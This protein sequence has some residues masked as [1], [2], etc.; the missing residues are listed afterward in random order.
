VELNPPNRLLQNPGP[1]SQEADYGRETDSVFL[2]LGN[3][4]EASN[5][6]HLA[7]TTTVSLGSNFG[8]SKT[9]IVTRCD[10]A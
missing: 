8:G 5:Q 6:P 3:R 10:Y 7:S 2:S 9:P 4:S 1:G